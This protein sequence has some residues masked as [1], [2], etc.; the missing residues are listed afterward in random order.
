MDKR[1][2]LLTI[3]SF[4]VGMVELIIGGILDLVAASLDVSVGQAGLLITIFSL[5]FAIS[6]PILLFLTA[7][8]ERKKLTL[9]TLFIFFLSNVLAVFSPVYS[10]LFISRIISAASASLLIVLC[11]TMASTIVEPQ[12]RGRAIGIVNMGVSG[13]LVLGIPFGLMLG[14]AF[15]WRAPFIM[16]AILTLCSMAGVYFFMKQIKPGQGAVSI[17]QQLNTLK[18]SKVLLAH[19]TTFLVL[20]GHT[21]LYAYLTPFAQVTMGLEGLWIS[22]VYLVFGVAA[23]SGGAIGGS[24]A[25]LFGTKRTILSVIIIFVIA[26]IAVPFTTFFVPFFFFIMIIWGSMSWAITPPMQSYLIELS[27]K[28]SDILISLNNSSLHLGIAVG[29]FIGSIV[30]DRVSIEY[31]A[32]VGGVIIALGLVTALLATR[33]DTAASQ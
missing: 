27:P 25:D 5:V 9:I 6:S 19:T 18:N 31:N 17:G 21:T 11:V 1:V 24:S 15:G 4:V 32:I 12:Y 3:V 7:R 10:V 28:N 14:N 20:A 26:I 16:I 22:I 23:V 2:Y 30:V 13:S 33:R 8:I 29:S